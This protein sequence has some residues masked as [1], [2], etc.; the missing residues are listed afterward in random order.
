VTTNKILKARVAKKRTI[1]TYAFLWDYSYKLLELSQNAP[2]GYKRPLWIGSLIFTAFTFEAYLNHIGKKLFSCWD[3]FEKA[4]NPEGK[5]DIVFE[6]LGIKDFPKGKRPR[7]TV[8]NLFDLRNNLA[9]GKTIRLEPEPTFRDADQYLE[10]FIKEP[11]LAEWEK[12]CKESN[13]KIAREDIKIIMEL[14]QE[15]ANPEEPLL[16]TGLFEASASLS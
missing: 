10:K 1:N 14:I 7:Q 6:R 13:S 5:L 8:R 15:K 4:I 3:L 16:F 9:H 11:L 2:I 12:Y